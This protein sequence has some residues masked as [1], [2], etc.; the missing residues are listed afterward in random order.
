MRTA[1][2]R[3]TDTAAPVLPA[4]AVAPGLDALGGAA[5][6]SAEGD[7]RGLGAPADADGETAVL[8]LAAAP[9]AVADL[10]ARV[11]VVDDSDDGVDA[12]GLT[13]DVLDADRPDGDA[14]DDEGAA[15]EA[16]FSAAPS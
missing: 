4:L 11:V 13:D 3:G 9:G 2:A 5:V 8:V 7:E 6:A 10:S 15:T 14:P 12:D 1:A 16:V